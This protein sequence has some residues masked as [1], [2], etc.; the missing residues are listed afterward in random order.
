MS[1]A[2]A[3]GPGVRHLACFPLPGWR[4]VTYPAAQAVPGLS[5][6]ARA[7]RGHVI[8]AL[9]GQLDIASAPALREQLLNLLHHGASRLIIDLSAV[10]YADASGLAV[11]VATARRA[12][13]LG[14][15][16]RLAAPSPKA[17]A[18]LSITGLDR[19]LD[20]LP[21]VHA[22]ITSAPRSKWR[23]QGTA[24]P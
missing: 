2:S 22:A 10:S 3:S 20:I 19:R 23:H 12:G 1:T 17:A 8:A 15:C 6:F 24:H 5:L 13:L 11:L 7:E 14:G 16:L 18:V 4:P 21:T 9:S